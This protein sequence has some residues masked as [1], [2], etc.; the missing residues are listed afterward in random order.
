ME[1]MILRITE[2]LPAGLRARAT[3]ARVATLAQFVKFGAVGL[4]GLII[5]TA[6]VY[7]LR[8][9]LGLYGA[10]IVAYVVAAS[11]N[12]LLNRIWTFRGRG[13]GPAHHQWGRFMLANLVGF[14]L[15]RGTYALLVTFVPIAAAQPVIATSAGSVAGMFVN[16]Y[17]SR[18]MVFR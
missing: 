14:A 13:S 16:F 2:R 11:V 9:S 6:T 17:L 1:A 10:G 8:G 12:W 15:N 18:R 4:S 3:A 5:D 7:A